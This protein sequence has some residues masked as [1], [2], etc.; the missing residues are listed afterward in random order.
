MESKIDWSLLRFMYETY[1]VSEEELA[2]ENGTT[3]GRVRF[4]RDQQN[5]CR[6]NIAK[7]ANDWKDEESFSDEEILDQVQKRMSTL[8]LLQQVAVNPKIQAFETTLIT[9]AIE[10]ARSIDTSMPSSAEALCKLGN[11]LEKIKESNPALQALSRKNEG[12]DVSDNSVKVQ[13]V[14]GYADN[15]KNNAI[16]MKPKSEK[17]SNT[18]P[19]TKQ[20]PYTTISA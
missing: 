16:E 4:V 9:K 17:R 3:V 8:S 14:T 5:W 1:G 18:I 6:S 13:I 19:P 12:G 7:A 15:L 2:E 10:T 20:V 11:L